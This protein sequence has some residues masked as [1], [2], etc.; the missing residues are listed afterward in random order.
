MC[1]KEPKKQLCQVQFW[2]TSEGQHAA[3]HIAQVRRAVKDFYIYILPDSQG[4]LIIVVGCAYVSSPVILGTSLMSS[5]ILT[6]KPV[7]FLENYQDT[8]KK[9]HWFPP[10]QEYN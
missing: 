4:P 5:S 8:W 9:C 1:E 7:L 10:T 3:H 2:I 6:S